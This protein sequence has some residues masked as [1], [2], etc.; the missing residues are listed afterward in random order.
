MANA[1]ASFL[2]I[3]ICLILV[4][5]CMGDLCMYALYLTYCDVGSKISCIQPC[6]AAGLSS[7]LVNSVC[8]YQPEKQLHTCCTCFYNC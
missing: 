2:A 5:G 7:S 8:A 1:S 3:I 4:S 6:F